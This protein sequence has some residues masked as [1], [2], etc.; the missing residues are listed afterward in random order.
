MLRS[1]NGGLMQAEQSHFK[2]FCMSTKNCV[3]GSKVGCPLTYPTYFHELTYNKSE[4]IVFI[5]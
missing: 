5:A 3:D 4:M 2:C 1:H